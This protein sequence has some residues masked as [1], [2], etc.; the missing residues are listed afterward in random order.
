MK[1]LR[2]ATPEGF[3]LA[4][5]AQF[6]AGFT[7]GSGMASADGLGFAFGADRTYAPVGVRLRADGDAIVA[8]YEGEVA[9][10]ALRAQLARM[11]GLN[12]DGAAWLG[13]ADPVVR[14]LQAQFPGFFTA[15]KAS[16]YDAAT[17]S[18]IAARIGIAQASRVKRAL[19]AAHGDDVFGMRAFPH[20]E[21]LLALESFP[22]LSAEK[23]VRLRGIAEA[24]LAGELDADRLAAIGEERALA[25]LQTLRG[26][27]PW[28]AAH[29]YFRAVA[30]VDALPHGEPR[31]LHAVAQ[32][33]DLP[34]VTQADFARIAE[35]WRPFRMWT[36]VLLMRA[37]AQTPGWA[38]APRDGASRSSGKRYAAS[39]GTRRASA[40]RPAP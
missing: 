13:I 27:G 35:A 39:T 19:T 37:F 15:A 8:E 29:I 21:K 10:D 38:T 36:A 18:I 23:L 1:Q 22:G 24:A 7:P 28:G 33:Y 26:I 5:A 34:G 20:P 16:P 40:R 9:A 14:R 17:W 4:A 2:F 30:P 31:V 12:A 25:Q 11:L 32:A 3:S 6:Y